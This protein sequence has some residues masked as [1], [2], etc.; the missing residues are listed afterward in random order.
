MAKK[1]TSISSG[2]YFRETDLTF[3][4]NA[5]GTFAGGAIVLSEKGPAFE[6]MMS[7]SMSER[8]VRMGGVN[9]NYISSYYANEFLNQASNYKEVRMLGLE[10]Y[11]EDYQ[12]V[13]SKNVGGTNKMFVVAYNA[14]GLNNPASTPITIENIVENAGTYVITLGNTI[15]EFAIG[16]IIN[17]SSVAGLSINGKQVI[18]A[19]GSGTIS[20]AGSF[21]GA[22]SGGGILLK[23]EPFKTTADT[24]ACIL[25]PRREGF[26]G[27]PVDYVEIQENGTDKDFTV[28]VYFEGNQDTF[29]KTE[30]K[31]SLREDSSQYISNVF[32]TDPRDNTKI[33]GQPSPL[34]VESV[35]PS[36]PVKLTVKG[37]AGYY[38]PGTEELGVN[39]ELSLL[40]GNIT[41]NT[42]FQYQSASI[43][44]ASQPT[45]TTISV[46]AKNVATYSEK[47]ITTTA[48]T[49]SGTAATATFA[50]QTTAPYSSGDEIVIT[51]ATPNTYNG[52]FVVTSATAFSVTWAS[53]ETTTATVQGVITSIVATPNISAGDSV[54]ISG[55]SLTDLSLNGT[56]KVKTATIGLTTTEYSLTKLDNTVPTLAGNFVAGDGKYIRKAWTPTWEAQLINFKA[57]FQ[58]PVTPWF[59][60]NFD[61]NGAAKQLFRI[62]SISDG[63]AANTEIKIEISNIDPTGNSNYGSF[64]LYV[65]NFNNTEDK[66]RSVYEGY[67]NLTMNPKSS[68]YILRRIGDGENFPLQSKFIFI[69][70]NENESLPSTALPYGIEGYTNVTNFC[71]PDL[72][73]TSQYDL[74]KPVTKQI[75]G[76]ASNNTNMFKALDKAYLT[77]KNITGTLSKGNGF[78]LNPSYIDLVPGSEAQQVHSNNGTRFVLVSPSSYNISDSNTAKAVGLNLSKKMKYVVAFEGGFDGWN[79]YSER[80]WNDPTSKDFE[81]LTQ[82][83]DVLSDP[84]D[85]TTDFSVL[86]TPDLNFQTHN[87]AT[88]AVLEMIEN[89]GDA[90]YLFDFNYEY[91]IPGKKPEII[92]SDAS[93][94]LSSSDML[95]SYSAVYYPDSQ[96]SD[97]IN[98]LNMWLPPSIVGL[99]TIARTATIENVW[100]P[101]AGS[102]RTVTDN[103]VRMRKRMKHNDREI[104]KKANINPITLFPGSGFEITESRTTQANFSALSFIHNRLLL[105]Y[106]K[107]A[108]NQIL[109]PLLHQLK[110]ES[111]KTEFKNTVTPIFERIKKLNGLETFE[112]SVNGSD[113]DRTTLNGVITISPLYPVERIVV[114]FVLKDGGLTYNQ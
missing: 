60:D 87:V 7:S 39:G 81:A 43:T 33:Y 63:E 62:W 89:R 77:F 29:P 49:G 27:S 79:V 114:D 50:N 92:P 93:Q 40:S 11:N 91:N 21:T 14:G 104:L 98:N 51:S 97:S 54:V 112:V 31:C 26:V 41:V 84:E 78:H 35:F 2:I 111:L 113:E 12:I 64:D 5:V 8:T 61:L 47:K 83:I 52:T 28:V 24:I 58:T 69:E 73:W 38:Y 80:T 85:L 95:S 18:S 82:A 10:G 45:P 34:W 20:V 109:R 53:V 68:N 19:V 76:L 99:A 57:E 86:V 96:L 100:Q 107:K 37:E 94:A 108:L 103:I 46:T 70:L 110:N 42:D 25:K 102:L 4:Q 59:V 30:I 90:L 16:D 72:T 71:L 17:I 66:S 44:E 9:P 13:G 75:L 105:G 1:V 88:S 23:G 6:P 65:R 101:P 15:D 48:I 3:I 22:Y 32:G 55:L 74:S 56:W 36:T 106:A 67:P